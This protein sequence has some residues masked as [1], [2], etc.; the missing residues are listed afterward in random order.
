[1]T[2]FR[3]ASCVWNSRYF[4]LLLFT[5]F[6]NDY[7]YSYTTN[8]DNNIKPIKVSF[9]FIFINYLIF[10]FILG[11]Y[12][13]ATPPQRH[14]GPLE[15]FF[16]TMTWCWM[17]PVWEGPKRR[18]GLSFR[19]SMVFFLSF[20]L[21]ADTFLFKLLFYL[22]TAAPSYAGRLLYLYTTLNSPNDGL[23]SFQLFWVLCLGPL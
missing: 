21:L 8:G 14:N 23:A 12:F 6:T 11:F 18:L 7:Y 4:F 20:F 22:I 16:I 5:Y 13:D 3:D 19:P 2:G 17:T 9:Y 1:M 15:D 10:Y